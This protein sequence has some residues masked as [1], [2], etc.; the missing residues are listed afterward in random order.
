MDLR[1]PHMQ[2]GEEGP[3]VQ[4]KMYE[5]EGGR[6]GHTQYGTVHRTTTIHCQRTA[7]PLLGGHCHPSSPS[8]QVRRLRHEV[9]SRASSHPMEDGNA[10]S[11]QYALPHAEHSAMKRLACYT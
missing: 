5:G 3:H 2:F 10:I 4:L 7:S 1:W 8:A 6:L 9:F 11:C